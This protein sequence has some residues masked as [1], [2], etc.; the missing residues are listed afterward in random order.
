MRYEI[1]RLTP[2]A[3]LPIITCKDT[4]K[5]QSIQL[6]NIKKNVFLSKNDKH[7]YI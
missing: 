7:L 5:K 3:L 4:Q 2:Y 1:L 6:N